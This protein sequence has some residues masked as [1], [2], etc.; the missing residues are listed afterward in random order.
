[1]MKHPISKK[2]GKFLVFKFILLVACIIGRSSQAQ[3]SIYTF[4]PNQSTIVQTGG[5]A[6]VNWTYVV[7]GQ[8]QLTVDFGSGTASF[9]KVDANA[10]DDSQYKRTLNPNE[11]FAMT[12]LVG[13]VTGNAPLE[14][15]GYSADGSSILLEMMIVGDTITMKAQTTPPPNSADFFIFSMDAVAQRK[16]G[17][18]TGEPN[19]PYLIYTAEQ[20]NT[21]GTEPNDWDKHFKLIADIDLSAYTGTEFNIIGYWRSRDDFK[22]FRG[23]FDGNNMIISNFNYTS[24][25]EGRIGLFGYMEGDDAQI[26]NLELYEPNVSSVT[27]RYIGALVGDANGCIDGCYVQGGNIS[28]EHI[29]GGIAGCNRGTIRYCSSSSTVLG[30]GYIVGGLVG[31]NPGSIIECY[32]TGD[33]RAEGYVGGLVGSNGGLIT[34]AFSTGSIQSNSIA[35]GLVGWNLGK[36]ANCYAAARVFGNSLLGGLVGYNLN[37]VVASF[38]DIE[39]SGQADSAG[40]LGRTTVEMQTESTFT[41]AGWD[42]IGETTN[43]TDDIWWI[44]EGQDYPRLWWELIEDQINDPNEN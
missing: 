15:T 10:V 16:Y 30:I 7:E 29:V 35:G 43:G 13:I 38:W 39:S 24:I 2:S 17:G 14:F 27:G 21:I 3:T 9:D 19:N 42:F 1:M 33:T 25:D 20:M 36:V 5:I 6:G 40:G 26:R 44:D 4:E 37:E 31:F 32:S 28:G 18:G 12:S 34:N 8:F 23:V 11:V 41:D 22:P